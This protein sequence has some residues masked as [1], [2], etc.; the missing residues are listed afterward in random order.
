MKTIFSIIV[1]ALIALDSYGKAFS[2]LNLKMFNNGKFSVSLN[3]QPPSH[4]SA[5][6]S[7]KKIKPG[8]HKLYV[9]RIVNCPYN[10]YPI[11]EELYNGWIYI[12]PKSVVYAHLNRH[13]K[14]D[15]VKIEPYFCHPAGGGCAWGCNNDYDNEWGSY[16][17]GW[18]YNNTGYDPALMIPPYVGMPPQNFARL[19]TIIEN[20]S[21][22]SSKLQIAKQAVASNYLS[23][24][25]IAEILMLFD[26][27]T[28]KLEFA[29]L[30]YHK[31]ADKQNYYLVNDAFAFESSIAELN[32]YIK[33][34]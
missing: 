3:N 33:G 10:Y 17:N 13:N 25:Q 6:F 30:A 18:D 7:L 20:Q 32:K 21:F 2:A 9:F 8:Y 34:T 29:K 16:D 27:E 12:P 11:K 19:K 24:A 31:A 22:E 1:I 5:I 15:I 23:S 26:F 14:I 28:T 4:P